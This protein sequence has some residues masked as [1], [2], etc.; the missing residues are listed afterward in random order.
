MMQGGD[1]EKSDGTGGSSIYGDQFEDEAF[2]YKHDKPGVVSMANSGPNTNGS[3]FF[4]T[5]APAPHLDDKH[6]VF[7]RVIQGLEVVAMIEQCGT[8][9]GQVAQ[10]VR[11]DN[12]GE[13][14]T[15]IKKK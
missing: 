11:I 9:Q 6:V 14:I 2:T 13:I 12:C 7:G 15:L 3:Q 5:S 8:E 10:M 1:F 4:I